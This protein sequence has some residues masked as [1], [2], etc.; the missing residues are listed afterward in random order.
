MKNRIKVLIVDDAVVVRILLGNT[1]SSDPD[2]ELV[3]KA[4]DGKVA[5][6]MITEHQ[7]DVMVLDLEMPEMDGLEVLRQLKTMSSP[8]KVIMFST[9]TTIGA[10]LTF[11]ALECTDGSAGE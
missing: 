4:Q 7:P 1:I 10:K 5:L 8:T 9:Y 11:E 6:Q 2:L 3:G